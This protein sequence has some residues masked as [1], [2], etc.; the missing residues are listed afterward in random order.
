MPFFNYSF[1]VVLTKL[2]IPLDFFADLI[3]Y[4]RCYSSGMCALGQ[5]KLKAR[6]PMKK[7]NQI[8]PLPKSTEILWWLCRAALFIWGAVSMMYGYTYQFVQAIFAI[9]FSHLWDMFQLF[10]GRSFITQVTF[11]FQTMLNLFLVFGCVVGTTINTHTNFTFI[12]I[13]EHMF[14][15]YLSCCFG[16]ELGSMMQGKKT[17]LKPS[18]HAM[19]S[20]LFGMGILVA[21][22]F[23]EFT[24]DRLYGFDMQFGAELY[25]GGL[26]DTMADLIIGAV[27]ALGAMF[28]EAFRRNGIIGKNRKEIR[29]RVVAEREAFK[30]EK[31][32][33]YEQTQ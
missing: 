30:A 22:E 14:A 17:P 31:K 33:L 25:G 23:Y 11:S 6:T 7:L 20:L 12:D 26:T 32:R 3:H 5:N 8:Q 28:I 21:W 18:V 24:M 19:F 2:L 29:A 10:G 16:F 9:A 13:P 1:F 27:G 15:G 4:I